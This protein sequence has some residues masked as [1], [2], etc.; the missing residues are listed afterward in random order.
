MGEEDFMYKLETLKDLKVRHDSLGNLEQRIRK[1]HQQLKTVERN[2][3]DYKAEHDA[4]VDEKNELV[5]LLR[6]VNKDIV[7]VST[8]R[9]KTFYNIML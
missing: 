7:D 3:A 5:N 8:Y 4:L 1:T 9:L 2:R 6:K